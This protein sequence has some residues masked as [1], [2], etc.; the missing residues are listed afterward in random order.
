M[1]NRIIN[2]IVRS[3]A[4]VSVLGLLLTG[5]ATDHSMDMGD[6][7]DSPNSSMAGQSSTE[8][9]DVAFA[10]MMIPHHEQAV[11]MSEFALTNTDNPQVLALAQEI[12]DAHRAAAV[13]DFVLGLAAHSGSLLRSTDGGRTWSDLGAP[14][15]FDIA[16]NPANPDVVFAT[17]EEGTLRSDDGGES[18]APVTTPGL[19][20]FLAWGEQGLYAASAEGQILFTQDLG[21][22]WDARGSL[23]AEP[24][25]LATDAGNVVALVDD[26][27]W[28]ST[29]EGLT[30]V[31]RIAGSGQ[32]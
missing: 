1:D 27:I 26:S 11:V 5:C 30:F 6:S 10:Q 9:A 28:G 8:M 24:G 29:D 20:A 19:L 12:M 13:G 7:G 4:A 22:T 14:A 16:I 17:S 23:G 32:H 25:A 2:P 18:F 15:I 3:L 31:K 21:A